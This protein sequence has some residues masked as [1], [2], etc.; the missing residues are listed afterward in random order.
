MCLCE[1]VSGC[2]V[3]FL[4]FL[5]CEIITHSLVAVLCDRS[6]RPLKVRQDFSIVCKDHRVVKCTKL[7][8][9]ILS[10]VRRMQLL[11]M[12]LC[13][14]LTAVPF[15]VCYL[16]SFFVVNSI[17]LKPVFINSQAYSLTD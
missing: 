13:N 17:S 4:Y 9:G 6:S 3:S 10:E 11:Y 2:L 16:S 15:F 12:K 8:C 7:Q 14:D 1:I 5:Y